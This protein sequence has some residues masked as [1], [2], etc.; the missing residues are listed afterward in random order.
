MEA[1]LFLKDVLSMIKKYFWIILL[2]TVIGAV[3]GRFVVSEG[4]EP[5]YQASSSIYIEKK[6]PETNAV[7]NQSDENTRFL[8]TALTIIRTP[9]VLENVKDGLDLDM[10]VKDLAG[11]ITVVNENNSQI[12]KITADVKDANLATDIVNEAAGVFVK[13]IGK[14]IEVEKVVVVESATPG[15]ETKIEH[16]RAN[17]NTAM[18]LIIGLIIGSL[19]AF[20]LSYLSKRAR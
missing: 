8:N 2:A 11:K 19:A 16:S 10:T 6:L 12:L 13:E 3:V 7:I 5:S 4:P 20:A 15:L 14:L 1:S 9:M 18:G 17:A